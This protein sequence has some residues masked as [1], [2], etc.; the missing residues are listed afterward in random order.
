MQVVTQNHNAGFYKPGHL[1]NITDSL[2]EMVD[3]DY[4]S[5]SDGPNT[6]PFRDVSQNSVAR[7]GSDERRRVA[8]F[9]GP[10][11]DKQGKPLLTKPRLVGRWYQR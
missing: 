10:R 11:P 9:T 8:D 1:D 7:E 3:E 5:L 6:L 2:L 4:Y